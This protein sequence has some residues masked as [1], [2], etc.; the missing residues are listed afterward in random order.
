M[1]GPLKPIALFDLSGG[2]NT[3]TSP[4]VLGKNQSQR[5]VNFIL[6]EHGSLRVR[7]GMAT[8]RSI[9]TTEPIVKLETYTRSGG[10][11]IRLA[12]HRGTSPALN[13]LWNW[14]PAVPVDLGALASSTEMPDIVLFNNEAI[15]TEGNT[16]TL[17]SYD[18]SAI[19]QLTGGAP[20]SAHIANHLNY[21]WGWNTGTTTAGIQGP[22][23]LRS[24]DLNNQN[25]WPA[26]SQTFIARD[27]G[28]QGQGLGLFTIA[29]TGISPEAVLIAF[30]DFSLYQVTGVFG[31]TAFAVQKVK[32]DMGCVAPRTIQ[33]ISGFGMMRLTH[34]GFALYDGVNDTLVSEEERPRI[35]GRDDLTPI[36]WANV[37]L[38][39]SAQVANPPLYICSCP[40][41]SSM[42][43]L[44]RTFVYDLIRRAWTINEYPE[45]F[46]T[47]GLLLEAGQLPV[48]AAGAFAGG[49][50]FEL[51]GGDA[52]DNG[53]DVSW[54]M[55]TRG[56]T[57]G[58]PS[59]RMYVRRMLAKFYD[60]PEGTTIQARFYASP[61]G[62]I[63]Q[64]IIEKTVP[65]VTPIA[66]FLGYG[67]SAWGLSPYGA[68]VSENVT[69]VDMNF[70]VGLKCNAIIAEL[71]GTSAG[72]RLRGVEFHVRQMPLTTST[73]Q[74]N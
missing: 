22:S 48:I 57:A 3:V 32:S 27:D 15:I 46:A 49:D 61:T 7:D 70:D 10:S 60:I 2:E 67:L 64:K 50:V 54:L 59:E 55:R 41:S 23:S 35:F 66:P 51:F 26:A 52:T 39:S 12:I 14:T 45:D 72:G 11:P 73:L 29:E 24:S 58:S 53:D 40:V 28:Q 44:R 43:A 17:N 33:F 30:K 31:A 19:T 4:Y 21:L 69:D 74:R 47:L 1:A 9:G 37:D 5:V 71:S 13:R 6:D 25:S 62:P 38:A 36:D 16:V 56:I 8:L 34:R 68:P 63:T 65:I 18:A 42:G 20:P